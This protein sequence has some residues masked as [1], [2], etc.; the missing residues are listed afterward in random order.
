MLSDRHF[1]GVKN[2]VN[3][4]NFPSNFPLEI[5]IRNFFVCV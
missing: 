5:S 4:L 3:N 2:Y 1:Y